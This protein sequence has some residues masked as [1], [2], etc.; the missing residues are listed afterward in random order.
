MTLWAPEARRN[1]SCLVVATL[2]VALEVKGRVVLVDPCKAEPYVNSSGLRVIN[3]VIATPSEQLHVFIPLISPVPPTILICYFLTGI[4]V[5]NCNQHP[6]M[7]S[8]QG[9][10]AEVQACVPVASCETVIGI[11]NGTPLGTTIIDQRMV[12]GP[13]H[14][15]VSIVP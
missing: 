8:I 10:N 13:A 9:I 4:D 5:F 11:R 15:S 6:L 14:I 2:R 12:K 3:G 7:S 1:T